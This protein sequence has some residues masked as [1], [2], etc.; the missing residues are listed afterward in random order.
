LLKPGD[1]LHDRKLELR[2][3]GPDAVADETL[4]GPL[5]RN[6]SGLGFAGAACRSRS[7]L[8]CAAV[9][10]E[11]PLAPEGYTR[12]N[13]YRL[14]PPFGPKGQLAKGAPPELTSQLAEPSPSRQAGRPRQRSKRRPP[15]AGTTSKVGAGA[16]TTVAAPRSGPP[17]EAS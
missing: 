16:A 5:A 11:A 13:F 15:A 12:E 4:D 6:A 17:N 8:I 2:A 14:R 9:N 1:P 7:W 10:K 3:A